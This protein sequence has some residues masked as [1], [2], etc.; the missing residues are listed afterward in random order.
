MKIEVRPRYL[1]EEE[2]R[3]FFG[4]IDRST[5]IGKRDF[6]LFLT[7][8]STARRLS[9]I[10]RLTWGAIEYGLITD[11]KGSRRGYLYHFSGKGKGGQDDVAELPLPVY[12]AIIDY[13][14]A[15][16]RMPT[17]EQDSF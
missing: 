13:L 14:E 5:A 2:V 4:A 6:A 8:L 15:T 12:E 10:A 11:E 16:S 9:E 17:I 7:Y 1:T 3:R